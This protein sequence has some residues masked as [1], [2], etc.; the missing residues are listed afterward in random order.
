MALQPQCCAQS[1]IAL[2]T[3]ALFKAISIL[4]QRG[5]R[6]L[7][8]LGEELTGPDANSVD[9]AEQIPDRKQ[10]TALNI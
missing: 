5:D 10:R 7:L 8:Q 2:T 1:A 4:S 6:D 9:H 3:A